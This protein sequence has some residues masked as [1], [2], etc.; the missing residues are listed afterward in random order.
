MMASK[1]GEIQQV[2]I[3][4]KSG[5]FNYLD[6]PSEKYERILETIENS[7]FPITPKEIS[8]LTGIRHSTVRKYVKRLEGLSYIWRPFF[9]HYVSTKNLFTLG[10]S[11]VKSDC[12]RL[13]CLRFRIVGF[14]GSVRSYTRNFGDVKVSYQPYNNGTVTVF[15]D[16]FD[17]YSLDYV[18]F[19]LLVELV[20]NELGLEDWEKV[21]VSSFEF[22]NDFKDIRLDGAKAVTLRSFDG[23][24]RR[25]YQK[26]FGIRDEVKVVGSTRV[27]DVMTLLQGGVESYNFS[28][29]LF[30]LIEQVRLEREA[31]KFQSGLVIDAMSSMRR[32][33]DAMGAGA[34]IVTTRVKTNTQT[35]TETTKVIHH[36]PTK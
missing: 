16:C 4:E 2:S 32:Y 30:G 33:M 18:A 7:S 10:R 23:S 8:S 3:I 24:F 20:K 34:K 11:V 28:R 21:T 17:S 14:T 5:H 26:H 6:L 19:R 35:Q 12:P 25:V 36:E 9:G 22:N 31:V 13:H 27:E 1:A 15:V 29:L